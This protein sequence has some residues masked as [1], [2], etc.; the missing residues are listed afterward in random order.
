MADKKNIQVQGC[1]LFR[2]QT[3]VMKTLEILQVAVFKERK[4]NVFC[5]KLI[6]NLSI[7]SIYI[8][9]DTLEKSVLFFGYLNSPIP[10]V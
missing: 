2:L 1:R 8:L 6:E 10:F 4:K 9:G 7:L 5:S 3:F